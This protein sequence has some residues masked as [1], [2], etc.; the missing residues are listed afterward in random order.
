MPTNTKILDL[1]WFTLMSFVA[2]K[3]NWP[4]YVIID[5]NKKLQI[6]HTQTLE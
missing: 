3:E 1:H 5:S 6:N 2:V 4:Y